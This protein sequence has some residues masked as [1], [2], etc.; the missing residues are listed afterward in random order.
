[1]TYAIQSLTA[2]GWSSSFP[3]L[4]SPLNPDANLFQHHEHAV[5]LAADLHDLWPSATFRVIQVDED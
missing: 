2:A 5:R 3:L 4:D 1:M